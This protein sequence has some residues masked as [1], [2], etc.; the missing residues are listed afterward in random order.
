[1]SYVNEDVIEELGF[2]GRK[3]KVIIIVLLMVRRSI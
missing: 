2:G 3:E 1:M